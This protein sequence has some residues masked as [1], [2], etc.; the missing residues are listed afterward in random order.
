MDREIYKLLSRVQMK[1]Q[2]SRLQ[3]RDNNFSSITVWK[4]KIYSLVLKLKM[5]R[6]SIIKMRGNM[7]QVTIWK[8][9]C[10]AMMNSMC[11][12]LELSRLRVGFARLGHARSTRFLRNAN[13]PTLRVNIDHQTVRIPWWTF[14]ISTHPG[15]LTH[16]LHSIIPRWPK[17][18]VSRW[19]TYSRSI[20]L[21]WQRRS[22]TDSTQK[23]WPL[24]TVALW[25]TVMK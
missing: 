2:F 19:K 16:W 13:M 23:R 5:T 6:L 3:N 15:T 24:N 21:C 18:P 1:N 17:I 10:K 22:D 4:W 7:S 25:G 20:W 9:Q 12:S 14:R 8:L 11:A